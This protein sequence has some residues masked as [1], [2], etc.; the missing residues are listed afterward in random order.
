VPDLSMT[1][2]ELDAFLEEERVLRLAT[3]DEDGWPAVVPVWFV[4][5]EGAFWVWNLTR[6]KRT[7][8]LREGTRCA[9]V[10]D[11]GEQYAEL[12]GASGR[13][14]ATFVADEEVPLA[15]RVRFSQR[16]FGT[17]HPVEPADHHQWLRL[18]PLT[19]ASWDFRK[20]RR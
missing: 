18:G 13:L 11:G 15:V 10:V 9:F 2:S 8:R 3:V 14:A 16:Y 19:L 12:R 6:A 17:D 1:T 20:D 4:W 7:R 5:H